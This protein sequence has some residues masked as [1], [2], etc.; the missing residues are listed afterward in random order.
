VS[1]FELAENS[2]GSEPKLDVDALR[3]CFGQY[4]T[5]VTVMT[6]SVE[7]EP[8]AMTANSFSSVSL[9]PPLVSWS[10][11][12]VS[13]SFS[14]FRIAEDFAVNILADSQVDVSRNFGRSAGD[15]FKGIGWKRGLNGLPLLDGAAAHIQ[16]RVANQFDGGDH[17][18][19]LGRVMAFEHF[20]R[21]LLLFAQGR[22][23]VAQDHPAIE[24]S[25][26]T[27]STRGPSDSF[28]AGLMYR[29]YGALAE[30]MEEVQR[31]QGFTPAE[32]RI[33]GAVA[34]FS[35]YT[36]SEL[37]PELYLGE[38]AAKSAFASLR[39]S[40]VISIDA[41]ERIAFTELGNAKLA[42]LL[43]ALR[44]QQ[45]QLLGGLPD[46]DIEAARR[47]FRQ[48]IEMSRRQSARI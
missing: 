48:M 20:D 37:M 7:G 12:R 25:V 39:A 10:I 32:A 19:L 38:S 34:T 41:K 35:G 33:L 26:D 22:Y 27:T 18:I 21:K 29:A 45:D 6:A 8:V 11:K 15:K 30:R 2:W 36:T 28:I 24:S 4:A 23:A 40:G 1:I 5:G 31:K 14:K 47:V 16:C 17:L 3:R 44:R 46:E 13:Q 43:D 9:D 42:L